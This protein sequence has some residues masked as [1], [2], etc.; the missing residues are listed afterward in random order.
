M[1]E[2]YQAGRTVIGTDGLLDLPIWNLTEEVSKQ[3]L[4]GKTLRDAMEWLDR[5]EVGGEQSDET[6]K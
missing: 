5:Q 4:E 6:K 2:D 3:L 1:I